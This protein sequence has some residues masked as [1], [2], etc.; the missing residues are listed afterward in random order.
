MIKLFKMMLIAFLL[1]IATTVY[2]AWKLL[3]EKSSVNFISVKNETISESNRFE[4]ITGT[5]DDNG[6]VELTIPLEQIQTN[7]ELRDKRIKDILFDLEKYPNAVITAK[8]DPSLINKLK[9]GKNLSLNLNV[10]VKF[11]GLDIPFPVKAEIVK[12]KNNLLQVTTT[13]PVMA[14]AELFNLK[15]GIEMLK[16][17]AGLK[18]ISMIVP[19]SFKLVFIPNAI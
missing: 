15:E 7:I 3:P 2:A 5:I 9:V 14:N 19:V 11:N 8:I 4:S 6:K 18:D 10:M 13:Q 16:S 12:L 17:L 1:S